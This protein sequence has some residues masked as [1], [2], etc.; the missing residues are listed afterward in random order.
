MD[1]VDDT[2]IFKTGAQKP[3]IDLCSGYRARNH[4]AR[5]SELS[6][7]DLVLW[8]FT[9]NLSAVNSWSLLAAKRTLG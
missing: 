1:E 7:S 4:A 6:R 5:L 2:S 9:T 8:P 3:A